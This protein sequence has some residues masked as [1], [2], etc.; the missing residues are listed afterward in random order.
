[1][2][3][4][5]RTLTRLMTGL[6]RLN[7]ADLDAAHEAAIAELAP[8]VDESR[9]HAM[10]TNFRAP[11]RL[12]EQLAPHLPPGGSVTF[13]SHF[14]ASLHP[15]PQIPI[16]YR[17]VAE[18][19]HELERW[20]AKQAP[21]WRRHGVTTAV[22]SSSVIADTRMGHLL[23]RFCA[24]LMPE[25]DRESWRATFV[26]ASELVDATIALMEGRH[27]PDENGLATVFIT[28]P[29]RLADHLDPDADVM[30]FPVAL[31]PNAPRW[32]DDGVA[33]RH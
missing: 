10:E 32:A 9:E 21:A 24:E 12:L 26:S 20:L 28:S 14:W 2:E 23:D 33:S 8:L 27:E 6:R 5:L 15:H 25:S 13:Y 31:A 1:M 4:V 29:G 7:G 16:Y 3:P 17:A 22:I 19:K 30:R 11:V 18:S